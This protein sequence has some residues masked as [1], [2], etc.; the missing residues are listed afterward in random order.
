MY[1]KMF[2]QLKYALPKCR[3]HDTNGSVK[4]LEMTAAV[5]DM[6]KKYKNFM[7][8]KTASCVMF[9]F[10]LIPHFQLFPSLVV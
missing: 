9:V 2:L 5:T 1:I 6:L 7:F 4:L 3:N 10:M 8:I